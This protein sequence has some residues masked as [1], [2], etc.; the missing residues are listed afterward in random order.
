MI[1]VGDMTTKDLEN[2]PHFVYI[3]QS[4]EDSRVYYGSTHDPKGRWEDHRKSIHCERKSERALYKAMKEHGVGKF[5]LR[6]IA[7]FPSRRLA[8]DFE[9][10]CIVGAFNTTGVFNIVLPDGRLLSSI[11]G[12]LILPMG[13]ED[14]QVT[15]AET[16][17]NIGGTKTISNAKG[18]RLAARREY[19]DKVRKGEIEPPLDWVNGR[20]VSVVEPD[21]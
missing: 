20:I 16:F 11:Q 14:P 8:K 2:L 1:D 9:T 6:T 5:T 13:S 18:K 15:F 7:V 4:T 17:T 12:K 21:K 10:G 3:I 19:W